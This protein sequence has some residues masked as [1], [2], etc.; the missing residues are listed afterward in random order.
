MRVEHGDIT[1]ALRPDDAGRMTFEDQWRNCQG[2]TVSGLIVG[3]LGVHRMV[4]SADGFAIT[5]RRTGLAVALS[6]PTER[7]A[8]GLAVELVLLFGY[9]RWDFD[10][11]TGPGSVRTWPVAERRRLREMV[12]GSVRP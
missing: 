3:P 7:T 4:G 6:L 8:I 9:D 1:T 11:P 12:G 2:S 5:H 10:D